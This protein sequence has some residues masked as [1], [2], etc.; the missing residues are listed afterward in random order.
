MKTGLKL[1][2]L[3]LILGYSG[4]DAVALELY[5]I[6]QPKCDRSTGLIIHVNT[7][8]ILLLNTLGNIERIQK[9]GVE[10]ILVYNTLDNPITHPDLNSDLVNYLRYVSIQG[11]EEI[12]FVGWPIR[13]MEELIVFFDVEG[14]I[15]LVNI[16][17]IQGF[18]IPEKSDWS[19]IKMSQFQ[20]YRFGFGNNL[21]A[22]ESDPTDKENFI[23]PTRMI[24]DP[25]AVS[26][27]FSVY[28]DGFT[29]LNR[30]QKRTSFYARPYL[31]E[32]K[33]KVGLVVDRSD[34]QE[35]LPANLPIN[36]QWPTGSNYGP[37]GILNVGSFIN[38][39]LPNVEPVF[40]VNF[41]GKYHFLSVLFSGNVW[42]FSYGESFIVENRAVYSDFF[43][44][45][46][47]DDPLVFPHYNQMAMTGLEWGP[48]S[49]SAGYYYPVTGMQA[50][51]IFREILSEKSMPIISLKY[52]TADSDL[53][54]LFSDIRAGS[55]SP[56]KDS[57]KLIYAEEMA[58]GTTMTEAS[59]NL[60][61]QLDQ[62]DYHAR[63][64]RLNYDHSLNEEI[65]L[66]LS[67][68]I[69]LGN[70]EETLA[71]ADYKLDYR[72]YI[73]SARIQQEFGDYVALKGYL[74][75]FIRQYHS[76]SSD[77][78]DN[79]EENKFSFT[80]LVEFIL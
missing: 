25:I 20:T 18:S 72:Q 34:F 30:F 40:A 41:S 12:S 74:N 70:Y 13:F 32:N 10:H 60:V 71:G 78:D 44:R 15:H 4:S 26:K 54:F 29:K 66:G 31:Y 50:N 33:T 79:L 37:Q 5:S 42:G 62:F 6:V 27:F 24:S 38:D 35:E 43:S 58:A 14:N 80:V 28:R 75:Y 19:D 76:K 56:S 77:H 8:E 22:C 64:F 21:P 48:Y 65:L 17:M 61:D 7:S 36:F 47:A 46:D 69:L 11:D 55:T 57:I 51:G 2:I 52:T 49:F 3:L 23:Q 9:Q 68:V 16:D 59:K 67:G 63:F 45:R 53:Q 39:S 73:T 1:I